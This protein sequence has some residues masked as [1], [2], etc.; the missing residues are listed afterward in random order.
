MIKPITTD[1]AC[2]GDDKSVYVFIEDSKYSDAIIQV[3]SKDL[4]LDKSCY[5]I[6]VIEQIPKAQSGKIN[7]SELKRLVGFI[8]K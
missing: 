3:L 7:Y 4:K 1:C 5:K 2:V 6:K 8:N